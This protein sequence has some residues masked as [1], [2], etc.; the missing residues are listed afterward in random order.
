MA[1]R[2]LGQKGREWVLKVLEHS[3]QVSKKNGNGTFSAKV[4]GGLARL[5]Q[6][7]E[8][9][10][11]FQRRMAGRNGAELAA[12]GSW[13]MDQLLHYA[14]EWGRTAQA[15]VPSPPGDRKFRSESQGTPTELLEKRYL[16]IFQ[17]SWRIHY[18]TTPPEQEVIGLAWHPGTQ[19]V[20]RRG[21]Q[22]LLKNALPEPQSGFQRSLIPNPREGLQATWQALEKDVETRVAALADGK[23]HEAEI[24]SLGRFY[25]QLIQEEKLALR[26]AK[27]Q[28]VR[29][30]AEEKL[31]LLKLEWERRISEVQARRHPQ[32]VAGLC[33]VALIHVPAE[34]W[35]RE[36]GGEPLWL[37]PVRGDTWETW[38]KA[39][40]RRRRA[41]K[42]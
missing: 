32:V 6:G 4:H 19:R 33:A 38:P 20:L 36:G 10:L 21:F 17:Y 27:T 14:G 25:N 41:K 22:G 30:E 40:P 15:F 35:A 2:G 5:L 7:E 3:G 26:G 24:E 28:R 42:A 9:L 16:P 8:H 12:P 18:Y 39:G 31:D 37:D 11:T 13:L 1:D 34:L 23:K 29:Q